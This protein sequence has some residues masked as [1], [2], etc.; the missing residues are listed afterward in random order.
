MRF[1]ETVPC[2]GEKHLEDT[3]CNIF[4]VPFFFGTLYE[5]D[6]LPGHDLRL[7]FPIARRSRSAAP[8]EYPAMICATFMTCSWYTMTP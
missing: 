4:R 8:I 5:V 7:L 1:V 3:L 6:L 2:K